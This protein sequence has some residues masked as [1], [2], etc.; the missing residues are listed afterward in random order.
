ME[1]NKEGLEKA[2]NNK[3]EPQISKEEE[4][5]YHKGCLNTLINERNELYKMIQIVESL[6]QAHMKR[7][8]ELGVKL[9]K[10]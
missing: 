10:E 1:I 2:L 6:M 9:K 3:E 5:G 7:L 4:T 8:E